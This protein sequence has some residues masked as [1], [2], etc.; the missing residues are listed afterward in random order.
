MKCWLASGVGLA[1][2]LVVP[3]CLALERLVYGSPVTGTPT[4][5]MY[6]FLLLTRALEVT[7]GQVELVPAPA[8]MVQSR[9]LREIGQGNI[10]V[11]WSMT[12]KEREQQLLP[13]RIPLDKGLNGY[14]I[15]FISPQLDSADDLS[16]FSAHRLKRLKLVQGHDWPDTQLLRQNG[17][18]VLTS[19]HPAQLFEM[20][21]KG[22]VDAFPRSVI[23]VFRE[24]QLH[25]NLRIEPNVVLVYPTAV[26]FFVR[27]DNEALAKRLETGLRL[28]MQSGEFD[29]LFWQRY[30]ESITQAKLSERRQ[31]RLLNPDLP[32]R[33]PLNDSSLW[34]LPMAPSPGLPVAEPTF[35][36]LDGVVKKAKR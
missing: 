1:L 6:P 13:V 34:L 31:I 26:Y 9:V 15:L 3:G 8:D 35:T 24:Q 36:E 33:T 21:E 20:L 11:Y 18:E 23:E 28:L 27:K 19:Q 7:G 4:Q 30:G 12:S 10:D 32:T 16:R 29:R 25:P 5:Q 17:F 22:R 2:L 14:R